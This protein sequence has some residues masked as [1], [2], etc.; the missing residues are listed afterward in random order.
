M[1]IATLL[2][3]HR[4]HMLE[5][6]SALYDDSEGEAAGHALQ[7]MANA[8]D[9][10]TA[11]ALLDLYRSGNGQQP[12]GITSTASNVT[13]V[14]TRKVKAGSKAARQRALKAGETRRKN[15]AARAGHGNLA[16]MAPVAE[17]PIDPPVG[18]A[19]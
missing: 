3:S 14:T 10:A 4:K 6:T 17:G 18:G 19:A 11:K 7:A 8:H 5:H 13:T 15:L 12:V 9:R 1:D 16:P 2:E